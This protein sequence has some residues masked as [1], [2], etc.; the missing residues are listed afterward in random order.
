MKGVA[1]LFCLLCASTAVSAAAQTPR[2]ALDAL[3]T[4][5]GP[6]TPGCA[7]G[8][9][10]PGAETI[11]AAYG[12]SDLEHNAPNTPE[13]VFEAGSVSKQFTAAAIMLLVADGRLTLDEDIRRVLPEM[14]DYG[15]KI[16]IDHLLTHTSG[17]RDWGGV[18]ALA[19][20]P[21][22]QRVYRLTDVLAIAARQTALNYAP[23]SAYSYTNTGYNL[24]A[25]IVQR[26]S[27]KSLQDFTRE[28]MFAPLGMV[29]TQWRDDFRRVVRNRAVAYERE[30]A[31]WEQDMPFEDAIGN[32]GLLTT[33]GDLLIWNRALT[34]KKLG[35]GVTTTL[36]TP[37]RLNDGRPL[38]YA[39][40]LMVTADHGRRQIAH[41]GATGAYRAW[42]ARRPDDKLSIAILCNSGDAGREFGAPLVAAA[43]AGR[44]TESSHDPIEPAR[45]LSRFIGWYHDDRAGEPLHLLADGAGVRAQDGRAFTAAAGGRYKLGGSLVDVT[46]DGNIVTPSMG[47]H[48]TFLKAA[49]PRSDL[50]AQGLVGRYSSSETDAVLIISLRDGQLWIAPEDRPSGAAKLLPAYEDAFSFPYGLVRVVKG[51]DGKA[52]GVRLSNDRVWDLIAMRQP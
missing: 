37:G 3:F 11:L 23:G 43:L 52:T 35:S 21:R 28:R 14:P 48:V 7:V 16:T 51:A 31:G 27:G 13:T 29:H 33:V 22:G 41:S 4:R 44:P 10:G 20:W 1:A 32:G 2:A 18:E 46:P 24:L 8:V 50:D 9:E 5:Y 17:L 30:G 26:I 36:E 6:N 38:E 15:A 47:D 34:D 12:A 39:H 45:D 25:I 49:P 40:G 19:G 42:L